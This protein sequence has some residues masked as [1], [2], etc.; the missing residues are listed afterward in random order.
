MV[1][2]RI[3]S[4]MID[5]N[6][7]FN[8]S[9]TLTQGQPSRLVD[10]YVWISNPEETVCLEQF[11]GDPPIR[12]GLA[13][14]EGWGS[15]SKTLLQQGRSSLLAG[16]PTFTWNTDSCLFCRFPFWAGSF[17]SINYIWPVIH[18]Q[19]NN[20]AKLYES[21]LRTKDIS[22]SF[23]KSYCELAGWFGVI[24]TYGTCTLTWSS[25]WPWDL[26]QYARWW[27]WLVFHRWP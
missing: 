8:V 1:I 14:D 19:L 7:C 10:V 16:N 18:E 13:E 17:D 6:L 9:T 27:W 22:T 26:G 12:C 20:E 25:L 23:C 5:I 21:W 2:F 11:H 3:L 4:I 15:N 24:K